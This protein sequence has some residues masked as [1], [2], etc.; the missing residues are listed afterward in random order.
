MTSLLERFINRYGRLPT[1]VDPDY[2][3]ML[4]MTKYQILDTPR[5]SPG[6]CA[7][8][9]AHKNDSR[10]YV[11]FGLSIDWYGVVYLCGTCV[12]DIA[13]NLGMIP[14]EE[15]KTDNTSLDNLKTEFKTSVTKLEQVLKEFHE[16]GVSLGVNLQSINLEHNSNNSTVET[17]DK[18][19]TNSSKSRTIK[20]ASGSGHKDIRSLTDILDG[21]PD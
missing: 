19:G 20:S 17:S 11:D 7:N 12:H 3:E 13:N 6:K 8:C 5:F 4:R 18:S 14:K 16:Y 10:K 21:P 15:E 1:E 2:L 9:G